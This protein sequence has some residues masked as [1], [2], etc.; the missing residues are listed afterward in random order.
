MRTDITRMPNPF[1]YNLLELGHNSWAVQ[2]IEQ[3]LYTGTF[4][5]VIL[6]SIVRLGFDMAELDKALTDM[7]DNKHDIAHFGMFKTFL[8][9]YKSDWERKYAI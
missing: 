5:E 6:F 8:Y 2:I 7:L 4:R 9:S 1:G 3:R